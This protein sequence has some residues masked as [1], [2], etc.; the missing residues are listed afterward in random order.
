[1]SNNRKRQR[2]T[3]FHCKQCDKLCQPPLG[4]RLRL[5]HFCSTVC[6]DAARAVKR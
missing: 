4:K 2:D 3:T 6:R 1:M 5:R